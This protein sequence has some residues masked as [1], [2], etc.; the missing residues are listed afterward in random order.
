M[1]STQTCGV[2]EKK[3]SETARCSEFSA[4]S[5][6]DRISLID[7]STLSSLG[8]RQG[9]EDNLSLRVRVTPEP[10]RGRFMLPQTLYGIKGL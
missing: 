10:P 4:L 2:P 7:E 5:V 9:R 1:C 6:S 3:G 8:P